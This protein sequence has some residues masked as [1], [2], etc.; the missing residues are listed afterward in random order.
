MRIL[1]IEDNR[2]IA[3]NLGDYLTDRGHEVDYAFDGVTGL[4][5]AIANEFD[6][7]VLDLALPGMDGL[8]VCRKLRE[9]GRKETPVLML[10]ARGEDVDRIIGLELGADDYLPKPCNPRELVARLKAILRRSRPEVGDGLISLG[11]LQLR[12]GDRRL[13]RGGETLAL[14]G[15]EFEVLR[16][17]LR[18]AGEVIDKDTLCQQ[19]LGRPLGRYDRSLDV[20]IS[21]LRRKLGPHPDGS[22]RIQAVRGR[23][24][25]YTRCDG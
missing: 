25:L 23:G 13:R 8:E 24:Y 6:A 15:A 2:D 3:A 5:L 14:T 12:P 9:E 21:S 10:T 17:L 1:I 11:D 4:H 7:M 22:P 18:A 19:A 16:V 20:H